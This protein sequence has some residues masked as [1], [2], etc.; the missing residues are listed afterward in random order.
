MVRF[1]LTDLEWSVLRSLLP[2]KL[3]GL[4]RRDALWRQVRVGAQKRMHRAIQWPIM[5]HVVLSATR[6]GFPDRWPTQ[7]A[8]R[9]RRAYNT[10]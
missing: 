4:K 6:S 2:T 10:M 7:V 9:L 3:R 1:D 5:E 8:G